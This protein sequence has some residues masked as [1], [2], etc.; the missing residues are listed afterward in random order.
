MKKRTAL[1]LGFFATAMFL[2]FLLYQSHAFAPAGVSVHADRAVQTE[3]ERV[4][5][6]TAAAEEFL[7]LPGIGPVLSESIVTW[8]AEHGSFRSPEEL[9]EVPGIGEKTFNAIRD[10]VYVGGAG[11]DEDSGRR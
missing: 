7:W 8:R 3:D 10:Y 4:D 5:L 6:N 1:L 9:L 2:L 11:F